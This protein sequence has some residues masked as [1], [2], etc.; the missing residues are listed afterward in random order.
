[1]RHDETCSKK[2][3]MCGGNWLKSNRI[4]LVVFTLFLLI[5]LTILAG[6]E[7][8]G[9]EHGRSSTLLDN[10]I[11]KDGKSYEFEQTPW[12]TTREDLLKLR[13][14]QDQD[15]TMIPEEEVL[16]VNKK[17]AFQHPKTEA[18]VLYHFQ[19]DQLVSGEYCIAAGS[20][21]ELVRISS[22]LQKTLEQYFPQPS[23]NSLDELAEEKIRS[24]KSSGVSWSNEDHNSFDLSFP[25][26]K[27]E[28]M[29]ILSVHAP[30][31]TKK[32]LLD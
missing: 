17:V 3:G 7:S 26:P 16:K 12:F 30:R 8:K 10:V 31:E 18:M 19:D 6:C 11:A 14:L 22:E 23:S 21:D 13:D 5:G 24:W 29:L 27:S 15:I 20:E 32:S 25:E 2:M 4:K 1:M 9:T 28:Y